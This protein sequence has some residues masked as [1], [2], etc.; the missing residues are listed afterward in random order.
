MIDMKMMGKPKQFDGND[1]NWTEW[2]F[3]FKSYTALMSVDMSD[4]MTRAAMS[5]AEVPMSPDDEEA[6]VQRDLYHVLVLLCTG[7]ALQE[8]QRCPA[9]NGLECWRPLVARYEP[10]ERG[11]ALG[12]LSG[13]LAEVWG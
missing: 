3:V 9:Y 10:A 8:L 2:S 13:I 1:A 4:L 11:R 5:P 12:L 7:R 6:Q